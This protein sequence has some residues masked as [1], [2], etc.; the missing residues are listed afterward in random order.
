MKWDEAEQL[1]WDLMR[2]K[3]LVREGWRFE[4]D[5]AKR[6]F[7]RCSFKRKLLTMSWELVGLNEKEEVLDTIRHEVAHALCGKNVGH[8]EKWKRIAKELGAQTAQ[9]FDVG[10]VVM[11]KKRRFKAVC[12]GCGELLVCE[13]YRRPRED[14]L[15]TV[16]KKF[17]LRLVWKEERG[18][19]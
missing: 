16:C 10:K 19:E 17:R 14:W 3:G 4:W 18:E 12:G 5:R 8:G 1:M 11:P 2:E 15:H 7:G 13:Q 9:K 6:R